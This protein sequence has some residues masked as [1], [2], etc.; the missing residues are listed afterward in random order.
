M[1]TGHRPFTR[2]GD[3]VVTITY[4]IMNE[5]TPAAV[6]VTPYLNSIIQ[7]ATA[8]NPR[9]RFQSAAD[10]CAALAGA[11]QTGQMPAPQPTGA[12]SMA[13]QQTVAYGQQTQVAV[14]PVFA[15]SGLPG[16]VPTLVQSPPSTMPST[17]PVAPPVRAGASE[18][19]RI[20]AAVAFVAALCLIAGLG[21]FW[22]TRAFSNFTTEA[23]AADYAANY[24]K[25]AKLY[26]D[27]Q[28]EQAV[29]QFRQIRTTA[30]SNPA[31]VQSANAGRIVFLPQVGAAGA[32]EW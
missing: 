14:A 32:G 11:D 1:I 23:H 5:P 16:A 6:G 24:G 2:D 20:G 12:T 30:L 3:S 13:Y 10:F 9:D 31:L 28:W 17:L 19:A 22:G 29:V 21:W 15:S 27:G 25:A 18:Q 4:R 8:K 26:S 7:R